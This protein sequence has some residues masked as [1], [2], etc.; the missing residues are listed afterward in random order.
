[1]GLHSPVFNVQ[2]VYFLEV[3]GSPV[4]NFAKF[5]HLALHPILNQSTQI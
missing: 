2:N 4:P 5:V 1:M 3:V